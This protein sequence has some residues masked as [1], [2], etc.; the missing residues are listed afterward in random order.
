MADDVLLCGAHCSLEQGVKPEAWCANQQLLSLPGHSFAVGFK[1]TML[2]SSTVIRGGH[3]TTDCPSCPLVYEQWW[4][5]GLLANEH[6]YGSQAATDL[7]ETVRGVVS[8]PAVAAQVAQRGSDYTYHILDPSFVTEY[9]HKLL[10]GCAA[11][12]RW[13]RA[14]GLWARIYLQCARDVSAQVRW[15]LRLVQ[16]ERARQHYCMRS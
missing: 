13:S 1:Y 14:F 12:A 7:E 5:A 2:C 11:T 16:I 6:Y 10:N 8:K 4:H 3:P 9:W 15:P